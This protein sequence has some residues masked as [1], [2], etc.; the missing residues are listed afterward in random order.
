MLLRTK[1]MVESVKLHRFSIHHWFNGWFYF[2]NKLFKILKLK[3]LGQITLFVILNR[4]HSY[5]GHPNFFVNLVTLK[6]SIESVTLP[7]NG[8]ERLTMHLCKEN[9]GRSK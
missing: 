4:G 1:S 2:N 7:L 8:N 9:L 3:K 6:K 5:F